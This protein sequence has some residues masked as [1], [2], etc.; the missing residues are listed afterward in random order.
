MN[1]LSL[2]IFFFVASCL[3]SFAKDFEVKK[4]ELL[5]KRQ[6]A[7]I[8]PRILME[9][10]RTSKGGFEGGQSEFEVNVMEDMKVFINVKTE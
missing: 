8:S 6:T 1:R 7:M 9:H 4:Y 2:I 3:Y 5:E 10:L